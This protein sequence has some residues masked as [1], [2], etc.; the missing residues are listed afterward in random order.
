MIIREQLFKLVNSHVLMV[1]FLLGGIGA[2]LIGLQQ[3]LKTAEESIRPALKV[4]VFV[5][6]GIT[7]DKA[8]KWADTLT[9]ADPDLES[10]VFISR[11]Q[12]LDRAQGNPALAKSLLLLRDNPFPASV[13]LLYKDVAWLDRPEPAVVIKNQPE[14]QEIRWDPEARSVFRSLHQW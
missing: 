2:L 3:S 4:V 5:Q 8:K 1:S 12:A 10:A 9:T 14:I 13:L 7:E 6:S 11:Q